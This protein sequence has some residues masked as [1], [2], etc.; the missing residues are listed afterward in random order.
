[1]PQLTPH[2][3]L[4]ELTVHPSTPNLDNLPDAARLATLR[5]LA[6]FLERAR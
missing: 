5:N 6:Q 1:M 4:E 2:F 3:S